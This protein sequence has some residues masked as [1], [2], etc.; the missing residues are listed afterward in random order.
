[1]LG[2]TTSTSFRS[3]M[4]I[5]LSVIHPKMSYYL[6]TYNFSMVEVVSIFYRLHLVVP[7][8]TALILQARDAC[9]DFTSCWQKSCLQNQEKT[10]KG[11]LDS[12]A[13]MSFWWELTPCYCSSIGSCFSWWIP[14]KSESLGDDLSAESVSSSNWKFSFLYFHCLL[15]QCATTLARGGIRR[16]QRV[17]L[18]YIYC[19]IIS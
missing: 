13:S 7:T 8:I 4:M 11:K 15:S 2:I 18:D 1:M 3:M 14:V 9:E 16:S 10:Y 17:E 12:W 5:C 6:S 19:P